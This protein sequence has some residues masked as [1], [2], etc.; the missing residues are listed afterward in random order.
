MEERGYGASGLI[1]M[2]L[3]SV[4]FSLMSL[5]VRAGSKSLTTPFLIFT[6]AI[7]QL[8][9]AVIYCICSKVD[10]F[11]PAEF[12]GILTLRGLFGLC[13]ITCSYFSYRYIPLGETTGTRESSTHLRSAL[14]L[15]L[16]CVGE[17]STPE[18]KS[19]VGAKCSLSLPNRTWMCPSV[20]QHYCS[21]A[22]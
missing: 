5:L 15:G 17:G 16:Y 10:P 22:Q 20:A 7:I 8:V 14:M 13:G 2:V 11:G 19:S 12:R 21:R 4:C 3:S 6:R 1:P 18:R 9:A